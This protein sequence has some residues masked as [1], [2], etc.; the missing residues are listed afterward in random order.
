MGMSKKYVELQ[1]NAC[2]PPSDEEFGKTIYRMLEEK[3]GR[4]CYAELDG[5]KF[6][7]KFLYLKIYKS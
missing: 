7:N 6:Y 5:V 2:N 3:S 4:E 1:I